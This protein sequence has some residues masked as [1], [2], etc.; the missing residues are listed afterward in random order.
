MADKAAQFEQLNMP[1]C[2]RS[3]ELTNDELQSLPLDL[4][5]RVRS[6]TEVDHLNQCENILRSLKTAGHRIIGGVDAA[7]GSHPWIASILE[8][9]ACSSV[10]TAHQCGGTLINDE[11]V[12]TAAHCFPGGNYDYKIIKLGD[13]FN[14]GVSS[15]FKRRRCQANEHMLEENKKYK[16]IEDELELRIKELHLHPH[17]K[18]TQGSTQNDIAL[19]RHSWLTLFGTF[20]LK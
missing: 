4:R 14:R 6:G 3:Y 10:S 16:S 17:Y 20:R 11:W 7:P 2:G 15:F 9:P 12:L 19:I 1:N 5:K 8:E 18:E 13:Y